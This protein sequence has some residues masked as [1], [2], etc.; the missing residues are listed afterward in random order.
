MERPI[1]RSSAVDFD[2]SGFDFLS[3]REFVLDLFHA[4]LADLGDVN[5][6]VDLVGEF[7]KG[8]ESGDLRD[9]AGNNVAD[10]VEIVDVGPGILFDLLETQ[11]IL[12]CCGSMSRMTAS[13]SS[14]TF[15]ISFGLLIL[16]VQDMSET[17]IIPSMSFS[18][19]TN[20]P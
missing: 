5:Q 8:S 19:S 14:P 12:C 16:R 10:L 2:D 15:S 1:R 18:I 3:E 13:T 9:L 17:W 11:E 20:A 4:I 6:T 7:H